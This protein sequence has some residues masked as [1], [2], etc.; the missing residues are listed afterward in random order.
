MNSSV[1]LYCFTCDSWES[2]YRE[3]NWDPFNPSSTKQKLQQTTFYFYLYL[4]KKIMLDFSCESSA[5]DSLETSSLI[6]SEKKTMKKYVWMSSAAVVIG[7]LRVK[8]RKRRA[9]TN[10]ITHW[11]RYDKAFQHPPSRPSP[12]P[13]KSQNQL[14]FNVFKHT[15]HPYS[16][17][18]WKKSKKNI[19][20]IVIII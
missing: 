15:M 2:K 14:I 19:V 8:R 5:E 6:F 1:G 3:K 12:P 4:S 16:P 11:V 7:A 9:T 18:L 20:Y 10:T 17:I 13:P